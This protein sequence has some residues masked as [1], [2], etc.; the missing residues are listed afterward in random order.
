VVVYG[1]PGELLTI[2]KIKALAKKLMP[3]G[4]GHPRHDSYT[5]DCPACGQER[6][7]FFVVGSWR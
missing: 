5:Y 6:L 3:V 2:E 4:N 7:E 1:P